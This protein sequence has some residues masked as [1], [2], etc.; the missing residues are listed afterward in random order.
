MWPVCVFG[1]VYEYHCIDIGYD[2]YG[3]KVQTQR[4]GS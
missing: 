1:C 2:A 4:E 3:V